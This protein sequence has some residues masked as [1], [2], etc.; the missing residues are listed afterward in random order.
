[1]GYSDIILTTKHF[2]YLHNIKIARLYLQLIFPDVPLPFT[3][4]DVNITNINGQ[5]QNIGDFNESYLRIKGSD[6]RFVRYGH[7]P[8]AL[9]FTY[10][11][12]GE[13][14]NS[15]KKQLTAFDPD[16]FTSI[17][18]DP[19]GYGKSLP[20][21]RN[22]IPYQY[23]EDD[24]VIAHELL[25]HLGVSQVD[26]FGWCD[27]A[28]MS[29][30]FSLKYPHMVHKLVIWGTKASL[31]RDNVLVFERMRRL[32]NWS[33]TSR[34]EALKAYDNDVSYI[35]DTFNQYVDAIN[36]MY[37]TCEGELY[38]DLLPYVHVPVLL[39]HSIDDMMVAR[40]QVL[41]LKHQLADCRYY[42][43]NSGGHSYHIKHCDEF[44][45]VCLNFILEKKTFF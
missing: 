35:N 17:F 9:F 5:H 28:H 4:T 10:G 2:V 29:V 24:V 14:R 26:L 3:K 7:G 31:S 38:R 8:R 43:F 39:L 27:G 18:W 15:F 42:Q 1:M 11:V 32:S 44:N 6:I 33:Q 16:V 37:R 40:H 12:L 41:D 22:F 45:Q 25:H 21:G 13:I 20:R 30:L 19:P 34:S 36:I 23:I